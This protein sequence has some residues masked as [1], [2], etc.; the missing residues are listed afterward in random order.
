MSSWWAYGLVAFGASCIS[1]AG[2]LVKW[3][4]AGPTVIGFYRTA[5]A[6]VV[7]G[8]FS[9][10]SMQRA[11]SVER[12]TI[13]FSW[14]PTV[15][16]VLAGAC[17]AADL[18]VWH[19]SILAVGV[20]LATLLANT[21]VFWVAVFSAFFLGERLTWKFGLCVIVALFG[22]ALLMIPSEPQQ[23]VY[24]HGLGLGLMTGVF[25]AGYYL[26]LRQS[27]RFERSLAPVP[28]LAVASVITASFLLCGVLGVGE[29]LA[30]PETNDL[31]LLCV[32]GIGVHACG[33]L[34][35]SRGI[36]HV[37]AGPGSFILLLQTVLA[38]VWGF[39]WLEEVLGPRELLGG[40]I[41]LGAIYGAT[42]VRRGDD[43]A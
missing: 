12:S 17:F 6:S 2:P 39:L 33:W 25:Y 43:Q 15:W 1:F 32:L 3:I 30:V 31:L 36:P 7:L 19:R 21:H 35:I 22:V 38:A 13:A 27:Q 37:A 11:P 34:A 8:A 14:Q 41:T 26:C 24:L 29:S 9:V 42:L 16:A 40:A 5:I 4:D 20:G 10:F 28:N 18:F 23:E